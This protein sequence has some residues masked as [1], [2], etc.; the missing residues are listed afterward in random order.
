MTMTEKKKR[1]LA[2]M[3]PEKRREIASMGGKRGHEL[4]V[5]HRFSREEAIE[6]G[7]KGGLVSGKKKSM[8][9]E[10]SANS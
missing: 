4:G 6:A 9:I 5:A 7:R 2:A 3:S 10:A 8:K 1:G